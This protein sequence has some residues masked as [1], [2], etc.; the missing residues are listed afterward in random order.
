MKERE[1]SDFIA[2]FRYIGYL[3]GT[4]TS[5]FETPGKARKTMESLLLSEINPTPTSRVLVHNVIASLANEPP[6]M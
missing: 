3:T 4:P 2:L 1:I 5:Y 6:S